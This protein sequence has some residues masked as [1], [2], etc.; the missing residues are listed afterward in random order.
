MILVRTSLGFPRWG[1]NPIYPKLSVS[2]SI[3]SVLWDLYLEG[4]VHKAW[5]SNSLASLSR[6]CLDLGMRCLLCWVGELLGLLL[7][8]VARHSLRHHLPAFIS[9]N[10]RL[11]YLP[12]SLRVKG[13]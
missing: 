4:N 11:S 10:N 8:C 12:A 7:P 6:L 9:L 13:S 5:A 1:G 3:C 2:H